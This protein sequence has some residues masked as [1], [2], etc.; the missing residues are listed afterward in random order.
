MKTLIIHPK[1]STTDFLSVIYQNFEYNLDYTII[2]TNISDSTLKSLIRKHDLIVMLGHGTQSGL[3][4]FNRTVIDSSFVYEL[5]KK[6]CICIWC[7]ASDFVKDYGLKTPFSTG[8][9][10][11]EPDEASM[12]GIPHSFNEISESNNMF[13]AL[14]CDYIYLYNVNY[15]EYRQF[16]DELREGYLGYFK[17]FESQEVVKYNAELFYS[18][19]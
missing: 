7:Y 2:R 14:L 10:I 12:L 5:R 18:N 8:M 4:G 13:A 11:S 6:I 1:D 16:I 9:F 3:L 15:N 17:T 19:I